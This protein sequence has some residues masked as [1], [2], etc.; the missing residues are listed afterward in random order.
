MAGSQSQ[1]KKLNKINGKSSFV[2]GI[3]TDSQISL[4]LFLAQQGDCNSEDYDEQTDFDKQ[5]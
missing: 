1:N 4:A 3:E 5:V 2:S